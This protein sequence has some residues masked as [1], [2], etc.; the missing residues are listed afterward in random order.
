M[1]CPRAGL[2][3]LVVDE[4]RRGARHLVRHAAQRGDAEAASSSPSGRPMA[5]ARR[6][7]SPTRR[8]SR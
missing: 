1:P 8:C 6:R 2:L 5:R 4:R 7:R 3:V